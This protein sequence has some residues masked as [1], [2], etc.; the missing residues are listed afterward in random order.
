MKV[1]V[2]QIATPQV[3]V[4][5]RVIVAVVTLTVTQVIVVLIGRDQGRGD[6]GGMSVVGEGGVEVGVGREVEVMTVIKG[7]EEEAQVGVGA[8]VEVGV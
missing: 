8:E 3:I 5:V 6:V 4:R 7:G 2:I 1:V